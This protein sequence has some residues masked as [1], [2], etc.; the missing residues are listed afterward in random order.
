MNNLKLK[1]LAGFLILF[2][3]SAAT[4]T[5]GGLFQDNSSGDAALVKLSGTI[6]PTSSGFGASG[7]TPEQVRDV[8]QQVRQGNYDAVVYDINSGGGSV[9]ASKEI[10][11]SID[12][13]DVPTVCRFRDVSASGAY[14]IAMGCDEIVADSA[15][16]TGSVGVTSSYLEYSDA[17][18]NLGIDYVNISAGKYKEL[19]SPYT[20]ATEENT[21]ILRDMAVNIQD[22]F[23]QMVNENRDLTEQQIEEIETAKIFLGEQARNLSM[24]DSL[25]GRAEAVE[26]AETLSGKDLQLREVETRQSPGLLSLFLSN[27]GLGNILTDL[28][29]GAN[30]NVPLTAE[31]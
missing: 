19:G 5:L 30:V 20:N 21:E 17:L 26:T 16:I 4:L 2:T 6:T 13:I 11:R 8:N 7:T 1:I 24:V 18:D 10:K 29:L 31:Y 23:I 12:S 9:V 22:E 25:G 14:M 27:T 3:A 15:T 28:G